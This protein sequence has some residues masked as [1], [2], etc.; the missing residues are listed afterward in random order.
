MTAVFVTLVL[1]IL[2]VP[3]GVWLNRKM[4]GTEKSGPGTAMAVMEDD[5]QD[6]EAEI[7][8]EDTSPA[9]VIVRTWVN[10][11]RWINQDLYKWKCKC[12][13]SGARYYEMLARDDAR[14]HIQRM[15]K[16]TATGGRFEW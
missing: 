2:L 3:A 5:D 9:H 11:D 8:L 1:L 10:T 16:S 12:G 7:E 14:E 13:V 6:Y 4:K 15:Q